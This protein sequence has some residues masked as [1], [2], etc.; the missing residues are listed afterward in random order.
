[1]IFIIQNSPESMGAAVGLVYFILMFLFL[2]FPFL[3]F[4]QQGR[5]IPG[6]SPP[7]PFSSFCQLL[8]GLLALL[9]MLFLGFADDV[10]DI[11]WRVKIWLPIF[12]SMP[13]LIVYF[14][15]Y[16]R[17]DI[18]IPIPFRFLFPSHTL[19][20]GLFYYFYLICLCIFST[21]AINILAG[22][23]GLEGGQ[24]FV[25]ACSILINDIIQIYYNPAKE[26]AHLHSLYFL[27]PYIGVLLGYLH[28]NWYPAQ[29]FGGDTFCYFSGMIFAVVGILGNFSK[30]V[31]LFMLP[32]IFNFLYSCPQLF[33]FV[34]CP[35]HRMPK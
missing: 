13:L 23:N 17:T 9:S 21:N 8:G 32:Q 30:T 31:L 19:H 11:K 3:T 33:H 15:T 26:E 20:L 28:K 16:G 29:A 25:I 35:R 22:V 14:V 18:L 4:I 5:Y 2:P 27:I 6:S 7:F 24:S 34:D 1:M 12:A 10:L